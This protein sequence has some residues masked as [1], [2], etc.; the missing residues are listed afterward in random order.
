M[1]I[2]K[3]SDLRSSEITPEDAYI[4]RRKFLRNGSFA[5]AGMT[6]GSAGIL[7]A[8]MQDGHSWKPSNPSPYNTTEDLTSFADATTY[9]N[10]YEFGIDKE[11]PAEMSGA[12]KSQPWSV[13]VEG[14]VK[15]P[16]TYR[17]EDILKGETLEDRIGSRTAES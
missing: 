13:A 2:G 8:V 4:N 11:D 15:K 5:L 7:R 17:L 3:Q 16:A 9:N 10:Y 1:L 14:E 12:F 6:M